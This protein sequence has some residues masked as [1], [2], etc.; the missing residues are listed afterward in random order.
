ME[1]D[2]DD[3]EDHKEE[4]K[5]MVNLQEIHGSVDGNDSSY[6]RSRKKKSS[7]SRRE[8][9]EEEKKEEESLED[10]GDSLNNINDYQSPE[11]LLH[12]KKEEFYERN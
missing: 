8:D 7:K 9:I 4:E 11:H 5:E 10:D 3:H 2:E 12:I 1:E 6:P